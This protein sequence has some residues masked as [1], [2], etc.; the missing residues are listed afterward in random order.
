MLL[1]PATCNC[2][3]NIGPLFKIAAAKFQDAKFRALPYSGSGNG[4][5]P[6]LRVQLRPLPPLFIILVIS[7]YSIPCMFAFL[8]FL[9]PRD[10]RTRGAGQVWTG[11]PRAAYRRE[12]GSGRRSTMMR[13]RKAAQIE[14]W[15]EKRAGQ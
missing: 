4:P 9:F 11:G 8:A 7:Q 10:F 3:R 15:A 2:G 14:T 6:L 13:A 5:L 1:R 12:E